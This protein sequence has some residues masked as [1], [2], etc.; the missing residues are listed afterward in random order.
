MVSPQAVIVAAAVVLMLW[1]GEEVAI[2]LKKAAL[3]EKKVVAKIGHV[4]HKAVHPH[5]P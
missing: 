1:V 2:G 3:V 5:Q 4:L